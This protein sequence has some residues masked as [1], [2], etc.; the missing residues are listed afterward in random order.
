ML[1][2][3]FTSPVQAGFPSPAEDW[4][5]D[6]LDLNEHLIKTQSATFCLRVKGDSM[7]GAGIYNG[8]LL[9]VDRSIEPR[10]GH[11]IIAVVEGEL[12]VKYYHH[13]GREIKLIP[14]NPKFK[15]ITINPDSEFSIWG[16]VTYSVHKCLL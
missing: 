14:A 8:D 3:L 4:V 11:T 5:E 1:L 16:V 15:A 13:R 7:S 12:T 6:N 10:H 2:P 9:I